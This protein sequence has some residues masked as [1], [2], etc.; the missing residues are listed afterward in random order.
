VTDEPDDL[1]DLV[2]RLGDPRRWVFVIDYDGTLAPIVDHPEAAVPAPG[3]VEAI[4]ELARVCD[5]A[6]LSGR[7]LDDLVARLGEIPSGVLLVGGHGNEARRPDGTREALTDL[8]AA[9]GTLDELEATLTARL[10]EGA[11]WQVERK[12]TSLAVHH[13]RVAEP[14]AAA[15]LPHVRTLLEAA[16]GS[17]PGFDVL[18]GKAVVELKV[19]GVDKGVALRWIVD[20]A[21]TAGDGRDAAPLVLGDDTTDE[22]AFAVA[23]EHGGEAI[24]VAEAPTRTSARYRLRDPARVVTLLRAVHDQ[25][26]DD[27]IPATP[28]RAWTG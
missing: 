5:V 8:E 24:R 22:D 15:E 27:A 28:R 25:L 21:S 14:A 23:L 7:A 16:T 10:D 2:R 18:E 9:R 20:Q 17:G 6:L 3:A 26:G 13:R 1:D 19:R 12:P 4:T 11:G